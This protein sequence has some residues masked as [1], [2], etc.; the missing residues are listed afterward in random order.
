MFGNQETRARKAERIAGQAWDQLVTT[1]DYAGTTAKSATRKARRQAMDTADQVS[2]RV[3]SAGKRVGSAG[4]EARKR[5][6][7]A[8][9]A[10]AGRK[11]SR[12]WGWLAG[13]TVIGAIV[14][15]IGTLFGRQLA[16]R[17]DEK[18]LERSVADLPTPDR[19]GTP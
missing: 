16:A 18:A 1:V 4:K 3:G 9:D 15:W 17:S 11:P 12:P 10:L 14:G 13:A 19:A 8:Y 5:A 2:G 6:N 7:L